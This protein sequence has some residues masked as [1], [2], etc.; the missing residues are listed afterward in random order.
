[1][2]TP[3][4]NGKYVYYLQKGPRCDPHNYRGV[5]IMVAL[6]KLHVYDSIL[7]QRLIAC[8]YGT[9]QMPSKR[10]PL[11]AEPVLS[12]YA[13]SIATVLGTACKAKQQLYITFINY[14]KAYKI[15]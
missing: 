11:K 10:V 14:E 2:D 7:N 5:R 3:T 8:I 12:I 15:V 6:S 13:Y 4:I 1:M 9:S